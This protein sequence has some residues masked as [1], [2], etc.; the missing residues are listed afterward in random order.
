M[1]TNN[2]IG[3]PSAIQSIGHGG[4]ALLFLL[5]AIMGFGFLFWKWV[6][7]KLPM[8]KLKAVHIDGTLYVCMG[9]FTFLQGYFSEDDASRYVN[10]W[11][12]W[13]LRAGIGSL[14]AMAASLKMYRSSSYADSLKDKPNP[15]SSP[16]T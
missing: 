10:P 12:L 7:G 13:W 5:A 1:N 14:A 8:D 2:I 9:L 3:P 4:L 16:N 6:S 11:L 15:P